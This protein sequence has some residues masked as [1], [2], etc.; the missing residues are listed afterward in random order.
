ML[1]KDG[2]HDL[3]S[4]LAPPG[5]AFIAG[6]FAA[7]A[8]GATFETI[9]PATAAV[10]ARV[11]HCGAADVDRAVRAARKAFDDGVWSRAAP[12]HRKEVLLRL[13]ELVRANAEELAVLECI[14]SGKTIT[15]CLHEIGREVPNFFQWYGEL[16][17]KLF[18]KV[19]STGESALALIV[20]EP[21]GVV[22]LVLPLEFPA[23]HGGLEDGSGVGRRLLRSGQA[24]GANAP[25]GPAPRRTRSGSRHTGRGP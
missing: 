14:D 9:N 18:G 16:A 13:A 6:R 11:A 15:D 10:V 12:E 19:A 7:A 22:G 3:A 25:F 4:R 8:D 23:S 2:A 20:K 24:G 21:A 1:T 5:L 17:D